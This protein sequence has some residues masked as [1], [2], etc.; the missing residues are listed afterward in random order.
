MT[1]NAARGKLKIFLGYADGVGKTFA[2]LEAGLLRKAAGQ[3]VVVAWVDINQSPPTQDLLR[4]LESVSPRTPE[5]GGGAAEMDTDAVLRRRPQLA[6]VDDLAHRNRPGGRHTRRYQD[7]LELLQSGINVYTTINVQ[8]LESLKDVVEQITGMR[9]E[10]TVPDSLLDEADELELVDLPPDELLQRLEAGTSRDAGGTVSARIG[11]L[12]ALR[13]MALREAAERVDERMRGYMASQSIRGPWAATERVMVCVS[14]HPIGDRLIRSGRRLAEALRAEW[15]VVYVETPKNLQL[16]QGER[17][18]LLQYLRLAE[19]LGA[20]VITLSGESVVEALVEFAN[21]ENITRIVIGKPRRSRWLELVRGSRVDR[22]LERCG[23][24]D[25]FVISDEEKRVDRQPPRLFFQSPWPH[26]LLA[27]G[28]AGLMLVAA[29]VLRRWFEPESLLVLFL[30]GVVVAG[31]FLGGGPSV[32]TALTSAGALTY[33]H[34]QQPSIFSLRDFVSLVAMLGAGLLMGTLTSLLRGQVRSA[35]QR[36]IQ[37]AA[38]NALSRDLT[39]SINLE[40]MLQAVIHHVNRTFDCEVAVLMPEAGHLTVRLASPGM[41]LLALDLEVAQWVFTNRQTA[42]S[43]TETWPQANIR[44]LPLET[45]SGVV[46]VLA[47]IPH[48]RGQFGLVDQRE[49]LAGFDSLAA[50]AI[51]RAQLN[52]QVQQSL[53]LQTTEKL[54]AALLN[55]I[56]HDLRTPLSTVSGAISSLLDAEQAGEDLERELRLDLLENADEEADRLNRLVGNLLDMTRLEAG[57]MRAR[58]RLCDVHDLVGAALAQASRRLEGRSV[59]TDIP[60]NL[61]AV[62][63]DFVLMVQVLYNLLDNAAKYSPRNSEILV[64][65]E[66]RDGSLL[67]SVADQGM[68]IPKEDLNRI[69]D[70]FYRVQRPDGVMGTGLGLA[71]CRGIVEVHNGRIWAENRPKGGT[72]I[73]LAI[74]VGAG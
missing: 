35:R 70:K 16:P 55:S 71:I 74:P 5:P 19:E 26:Y 57:A 22:L 14:A 25:V 20:Q 9:V 31:A 68:G 42:G 10:D 29:L 56:S 43:G 27:L 46:G 28:L 1:E 53:L 73:T 6:L 17:A 12:A 34:G 60:E 11:E 4:E 21:Q 66:V 37:T 18:R 49:L 36:E 45:R 32:V 62:A 44:C 8:N 59:R 50:L 13:Q 67:I 15:F 48:D 54:Q 58:I 64:A 51:E 69:F 61:P 52:E 41:K 40:E 39:I 72:Q 23:D 30:V 47:V 33:L 65:A 2:M 7:V 38:I 24:T 3:D 63:L